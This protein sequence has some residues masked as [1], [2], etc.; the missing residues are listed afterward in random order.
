MTKRLHALNCSC[1]YATKRP[2][3]SWG[4]K[5]TD[6]LRIITLIIIGAMFFVILGGA[7]M[8]IWDV[9]L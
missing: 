3:R 2:P 6:W 9:T 4:R 7:A 8:A 1:V 5:R